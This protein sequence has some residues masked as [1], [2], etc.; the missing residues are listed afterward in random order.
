MTAASPPEQQEPAKERAARRWNLIYK[1]AGASALGRAVSMVC[2]LAQ[3]PI[4]LNHLGK[5][6]FG[7]WMTLTGAVSLLNFADVGIGLGMQNKISEAHGRDDMELARDIFLTGFAVL[8]GIAVV[9]FCGGLLAGWRVD[10]ASIFKVENPDVRDHV[11]DGL[12]VVFAAFCLGFP[13]S[14]AQKLAVGLQL[15][16]LQAA[17]SLIGSIISLILVAGAAMLHLSFVPFLAVAVLPPVLVNFG[18]LQR[19]FLQLHWKFDL[20]RHANKRHAREIFGLGTLFLIPQLAATVVSTAPP[21]ILASVLGAAAVAPFNLTQRLL[22]IIGQ[23]QAMVIVPLWPAYAEAKSRGDYAWIRNAFY[24]SL[25][26]SAAAIIVP[27]TLFGLI[28]R[29]LIL[30]WTHK[31]EAVPTQ[32][33]LWL[34]CGWA[35]V[36]G[37]A[38]PCSMF[39][40]GLGRLV[41]QTI[42]GSMAA[43][44]CLFLM[45]A[46]AH[47]YGAHGIPL[48]L[49][50]GYVPIHLLF[51]YGECFFVLAKLKTRFTR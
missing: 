21:V 17:G 7:L 50:L 34:M 51:T 33:L 24:R 28:G 5:E 13:L 48:A 3:I 8:T 22:G 43:I 35:F 10:W 14:A 26:Y 2:S 44:V 30:L 19:L 25:L 11:R 31:P 23:A 27:L 16:W 45:P 38:T 42:Y 41:G 18:L 39:L 1:A 20:L 47:R 49:I 29:P 37:A 32:E 4:A 15:G 9:L 6:S 40:N 46:L 12:V 36:L